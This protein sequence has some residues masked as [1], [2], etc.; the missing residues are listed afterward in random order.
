MK[1]YIIVIIALICIFLGVNMLF[2]G[3]WTQKADFVGAAR[4]SAVGFSIGSK[5]YIGTGYDGTTVYNDFWAYDPTV[6]TLGTWTQKAYLADNSGNWY[7]S[8]AVGFATDSKGY[9]GTG[10]NVYYD[11]SFWE[12]DPTADT[13]TRKAYF[14]GAER[15][16]AVGFSIDS[17]GYI[18]TGYNSAPT[19]YKDFWEY[20]PTTNAWTPMANFG[21]AARDSAVGF[22]IDIIG[23]IGTG[24]D[25]TTEYKDFWKYDSG[26]WTQMA[27]FGGAARYSAVGFS[28][29]SKGYIGTGYDGATDTKTFGNMTLQPILG[30][31]KPISVGQ[32]DTVLSALLSVARAT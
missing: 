12:Y 30:H 18:G 28:I 17:K 14:A 3:T 7:S 32:R 24:Y 29:G 26:I 2:A 23:Y 8:G 1:K 13:W 16:F 6:G 27:D 31:G 19:E 5:G 10:G 25:G 4:D 15:A 11:N 9:I 22:S 20:D 21:G